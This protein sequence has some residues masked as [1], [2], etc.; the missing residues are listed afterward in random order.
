MY[1]GLFTE[2]SHKISSYYYSI[3]CKRSDR[4]LRINI[5]QFIN[6]LFLLNRVS[7]NNNQIFSKIFINEKKTNVRISNNIFR[8]QLQCVY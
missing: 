2:L 3:V 8:G 4:S 5:P 1:F 7:I 6:E